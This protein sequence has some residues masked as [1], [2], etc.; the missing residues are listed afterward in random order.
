MARIYGLNGAL[1]GKQGN[2]V[3]SIQNGTQVVKAYQ[4]V[5]SNPKSFLQQIQRS[6]FALAGK[7]SSLVPSGALVGMEGESKRSRRAIFVKSLVAVSTTTSTPSAGGTVVTASIDYL[8]I[9]FSAGSLVS[10]SPHTGFTAG[11]QGTTG[12]YRLRVSLNGYSVDAIQADAPEGYGELLVVCMFNPATSELD[13]CQYA[14]R[15]NDAL[16][17]DFAVFS[18]SVCHVALYLVPFAPLQG[19]SS[20]GAS[21]YLGNGESAVT[22]DMLNRDYLAGM[23][24]GKS[25]CLFSQ[26]VAATSSM[27]APSP[28]DDTRKKK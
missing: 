23:T 25:I 27:S 8:K 21:G 26:D 19:R 6:K 15:G 1:R 7:I 16:Q 22:L 3:F 12:A 24:F 14:I 28:D 13:A 2:N 18:R 5:V 4:P 9:R 10:H 11:Y 17:M 20:F